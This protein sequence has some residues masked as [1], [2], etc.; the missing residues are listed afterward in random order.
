MQQTRQELDSFSTVA[1]NASRQNGGKAASL[2]DR[3]PR[4]LMIHNCLV[5]SHPSAPNWRIIHPPHYTEA[6]AAAGSSH[7]YYY[8][9]LSPPLPSVAGSASYGLSA[10]TR[11]E[12]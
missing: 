9:V 11:C 10:R 7:C 2:I 3:T 5:V 1:N 4:S 6:A 12:R 8:H